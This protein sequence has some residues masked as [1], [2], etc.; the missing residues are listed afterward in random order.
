MEQLAPKQQQEVS[1]TSTER[2]RLLL[3]KAGADIEGEVIG[4]VDRPTLLNTYAE[5]L[6][7]PPVVA[8]AGVKPGGAYWY[9]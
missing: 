3:V 8:E 4:S 6:I 7:N 2:L 9:E 5:Y 1:K